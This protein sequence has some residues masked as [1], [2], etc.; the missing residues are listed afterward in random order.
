MIH[1]HTHTLALIEDGC[2]PEEWGGGYNMELLKTHILN[3]TALLD[4]I[5]LFVDL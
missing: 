5:Y 3:G 4:V 2:S 1:I